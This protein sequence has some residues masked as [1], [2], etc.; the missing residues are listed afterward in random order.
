MTDAVSNGLHHERV[1]I[2]IKEPALESTNS[3]EL[4]GIAVDSK[5]LFDDDITNLCSKTNQKLH[6]L[7]RVASYMSLDKIKA[8]FWKHLLPCNS[9]IVH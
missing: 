1:K 5:V 6:A 2:K 3:E 7:S 9:I 8:Y 4:F